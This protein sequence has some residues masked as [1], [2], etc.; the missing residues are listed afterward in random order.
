MLPTRSVERTEESPLSNHMVGDPPP[1]PFGSGERGVRSPRLG[2]S[3]VALL[4]H[5]TGG[6]VWKGASTPLFTQEVTFLWT[7]FRGC[8][9]DLD[10]GCGGYVLCVRLRPWLCH[11]SERDSSYAST[12]GYS[13]QGVN[14]D[15][16]ILDI[17]L[18][19]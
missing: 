7:S 13:R 17:Q 12:Y 4:L 2:V 6:N 3:T 19:V 1:S 14:Y 5:G 9:I 16:W 10:L 15:F 18:P 8:A 11:C